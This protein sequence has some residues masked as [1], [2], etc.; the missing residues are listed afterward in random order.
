MSDWK[1]ILPSTSSITEEQL[2]QYLE[3]DASPELRFE[4]EKQMSESPFLDDAV[5][6]LQ[7]YKSPTALSALQLQLRKQ[8]KQSLKLKAKRN[9]RKLFQHQYWLIYAVL[10]VLI[11]CIIAYLIIHF[12]GHK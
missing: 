11:L 1:N 12:Y 5:E 4:I 3:G 6:G 7:Q 2:I 10:G 8:L 9:K